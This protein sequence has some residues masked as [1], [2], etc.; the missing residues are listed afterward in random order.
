[1]YLNSHMA[2]GSLQIDFGTYPKVKFQQQHSEYL[3]P[4][5]LILFNRLMVRGIKDSSFII[6]HSSFIYDA[7]QNK[8]HCKRAG[9]HVG[10][11]TLGT[12]IAHLFS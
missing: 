5:W 8:I 4:V 12:G 6:Y 11:G 3:L 10:Y 9:E 1:M 2:N 7:Y